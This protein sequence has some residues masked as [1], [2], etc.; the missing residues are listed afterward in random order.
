MSAEVITIIIC[1]AA[2]ATSTLVQAEKQLLEAIGKKYISG[3]LAA[4]TSVIVGGFIFALYINI[5][6]IEF[7]AVMFLLMVAVMVLSWACSQIGYDKVKLIVTQI[8][9]LHLFDKLNK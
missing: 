2:I 8:A 6:N 3:M 7:D 5:N 4:Y 9:A 1:A